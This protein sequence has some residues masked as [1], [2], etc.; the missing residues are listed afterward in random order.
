MIIKNQWNGRRNDAGP[1]VK[2]INLDD[3]TAKMLRAIIANTGQKP[4]TETSNA[5]VASLIR[6]RWAELDAQWQANAD[7]LAAV[8]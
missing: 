5:Y 4:G 1:A 6:E 7:E 3:A 2:R 8:I